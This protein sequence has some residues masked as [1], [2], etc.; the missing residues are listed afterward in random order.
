[1][2]LP[3][4]YVEFQKSKRGLLLTATG[5]TQLLFELA[6]NCIAHKRKNDNHFFA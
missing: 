4:L 3:L 6:N 1:M 5:L 2:S